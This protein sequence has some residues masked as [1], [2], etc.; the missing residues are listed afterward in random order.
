MYLEDCC[1]C[2]RREVGKRWN[3]KSGKSLSRWSYPGKSI[4][5]LALVSL[6]SNSSVRFR[7]L[8]HVCRGYSVLLINHM[9]YAAIS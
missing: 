8:G 6:G 9:Q 5:G 2:R 3:Q 1:C 4:S 7:A